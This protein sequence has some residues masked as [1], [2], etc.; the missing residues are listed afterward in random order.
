MREGRGKRGRR[1]GKKE[2]EDLTLM[3]DSPNQVYSNTHFYYRIQI[4]FIIKHPALLMSGHCSCACIIHVYKISISY[5]YHIEIEI[6][7]SNHH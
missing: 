1:R 5:R 6:L 7:T 4:I 2:G 3:I